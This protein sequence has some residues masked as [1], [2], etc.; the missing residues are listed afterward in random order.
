MVRRQTLR[1]QVVHSPFASRGM[2][3][4]E[5]AYSA[6]ESETGVSRAYEALLELI[7]FGLTGRLP[8]GSSLSE[9]TALSYKDLLTEW[10]KGYL[11]S[12]EVCDDIG[13]VMETR[14]MATF[15]SAGQF[16]T[17][18]N[19]CRMMAH[20]NL[21]TPEG[22]RAVFEAKGA[23]VRIVDPAVGTGRMLLAAIEYAGSWGVPFTVHGIDT[24]IRMVRA[25]Q[26]NIILANHW[27]S[28]RGVPHVV[29]G[30]ALWANSLEVEAH[31]PDTWKHAGRWEQP[32]WSSL[33]ALGSGLVAEPAKPVGLFAFDKGA[34]PAAPSSRRAPNLRTETPRRRKPEAKPA[35]R[36]ARLGGA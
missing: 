36:Q 10:F 27:L 29:E 9:E 3:H 15:D 35:P 13:C 17:P 19:V 25:T 7:C 31:H 4:L 16:L 20:M 1:S 18:M 34:A 28:A 24:D 5:Q 2:A 30:Q 21:G 8:K 23:P 14:A 12:P 26:L 33:P 22:L 32:H 6:L 11:S